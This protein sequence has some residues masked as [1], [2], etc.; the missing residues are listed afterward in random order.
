MWLC[1]C[2]CGGSK[3]G[4]GWKDEGTEDEKRV[5]K[6]GGGRCSGQWKS[7]R[8]KVKDGG[9]GSKQGVLKKEIG[10]GELGKTGNE[11]EGHIDERHERVGKKDW[12]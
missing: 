12:D 5:K 8:V 4:L 7:K 9:Q 1:V 10:M 2:V 3:E 6:G 11:T